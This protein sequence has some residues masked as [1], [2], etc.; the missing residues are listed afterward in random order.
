[1]PALLE[2]QPENINLTTL[3]DVLDTLKGIAVSEIHIAKFLAR[4]STEWKSEISRAQCSNIDAATA[5]N[6]TNYSAL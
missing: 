2:N 4:P 6:R 3:C 1:M 5:S